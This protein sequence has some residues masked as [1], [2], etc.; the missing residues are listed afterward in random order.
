VEGNS[1]R[2]T[3][4]LTGAAKNFARPHQMLTKAADGVKTTPAMAAG[5]ADHVWTLTEIMTDSP[6][7]TMSGLAVDV[8]LELFS[9]LLG[10]PCA[11]RALGGSR[12]LPGTHD[13]DFPANS[14]PPIFRC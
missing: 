8:Q 1:I 13:A 9:T 2:A 10:E 14:S 7:D 12:V 11:E 4:R 5:V 3:A 6:A